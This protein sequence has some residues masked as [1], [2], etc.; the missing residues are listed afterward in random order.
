MAALVFASLVSFFSPAVSSVYW[1]DR[2]G[3]NFQILFSADLDEL[4]SCLE[5]GFEARYRIDMKLCKR[6]E[7]WFDSCRDSRPV[8]HRVQY[9]A[10]SKSFTLWKDTHGDRAQPRSE[11]F[12]SLEELEV[13]LL[14][15]DPISLSLLARGDQGLANHRRAYLSLFLES[16]C[17]GSFNQSL[18]ELSY[19][20]TFGMLN[21]GSERSGWKDVTLRSMTLSPT[22]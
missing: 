15:T 11:T 17:H 8:I 6:R 4:R 21:I 16:S 22:R 3:G 5:S 9:E 20:L 12:R 19:V 13:A 18:A 14:R 2:E 1:S 10:I 7:N